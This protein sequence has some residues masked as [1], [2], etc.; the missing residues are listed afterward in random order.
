MLVCSVSFSAITCEL[1]E[2]QRHCIFIDG[3]SWS[4]AMHQELQVGSRD[5]PPLF[6]Q[7]IYSKP[8][9]FLI[10]I[11]SWNEF[12][13]CH[14]MDAPGQPAFDRFV[15]GI[16]DHCKDRIVESGYRSHIFLD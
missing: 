3:F 5:M 13:I 14:Y 12:Y 15:R 4:P 16:L 8:A 9:H 11:D 1:L 2:R 7:K 10:G 6:E